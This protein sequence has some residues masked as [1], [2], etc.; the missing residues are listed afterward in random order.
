MGALRRRNATAKAGS[1]PTSWPV[2]SG[3]AEGE[4]NWEDYIVYTA[5]RRKR[6]VIPPEDAESM[7]VGMSLLRDMADGAPLNEIP[8]IQGAIEIA[9]VGH[10]DSSP[11]IAEALVTDRRFI[12]WWQDVRGRDPGLI[13]MDH[14]VMI[15]RP[16]VGARH[17]YMWDNILVT[18]YP[19]VMPAF[20]NPYSNAIF[21]IGVFFSKDGHAN[22][23]SMSVQATLNK[24]ESRIRKG[25]TI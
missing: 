5:K 19:V 22:R 2:N 10:L 8:L 3:V 24:V 18:D 12:V 11:Y 1:Y 4:R 13:I 7:S 6:E 23:R 17:P 21:R 16:E 20:V 14:E 25:K 15:P 9:W